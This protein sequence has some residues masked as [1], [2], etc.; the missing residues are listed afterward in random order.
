MEPDLLAASERIQE[1][2]EIGFLLVSKADRETL[3]I[4]V[5]DVPQGGGRTI[6]EIRRACREPAQDRSLES[7]DILAF[8]ADHGAARVGDLVDAAGERTLLQVS[9]NTGSPAMSSTGG[10]LSPASGTPMSNGALTEWFPIFGES[11]QVPQNPGM[12]STLRSSLRPATPVML[13][14]VLLNS[15]LAARHRAAMFA[16]HVVLMIVVAPNV[17][18]V[19]VLEQRPHARHRL[20]IIMFVMTIAG[21]SQVGRGR[22]SGR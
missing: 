3:V 7:A 18:N 2:D 10:F 1:I 15:F 19:D 14:L 5:D 11:W 17:G 21:A 4:E 9:V 8:A 12:L 6:V 20:M 13:I 16:H 22:R